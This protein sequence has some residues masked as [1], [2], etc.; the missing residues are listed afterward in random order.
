[1]LLAVATT[2]SDI[3]QILRETFLRIGEVTTPLPEFQQR[4][5]E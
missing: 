3:R 1:M 2:S 5:P 4:L